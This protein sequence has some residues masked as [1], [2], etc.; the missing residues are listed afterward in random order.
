VRTVEYRLGP[1]HRF[2]APLDDCYLATQWAAE[3]AA[4]LGGDADRLVVIGDSAGGNL[5]AAVSLMA[6]DK[7]G[8]A[9]AQQILLYPATDHNFDTASY[10]EN[11]DGYMLT[12]ESCRWFW[13]NYI[14]DEADAASPYV[15]M[16]R[17]PDL[18]GLPSALVVTAEFDPLRDEGEA[19][20]KRLR[21]AG[22]Q[23]KVSCYDGMIHGFLWMGGVFDRTA[24][25]IGEIAAEVKAGP[26]VPVPA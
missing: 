1:E 8:P 5:A 7:G 6:R 17:A 14:R 24:Q 3:H 26:S 9:I 18:S 10:R 13:S 15:S 25:L 21:A 2:P 12:R 16:L 23:A 19:Y 20:A 22:V 4:E 11:A